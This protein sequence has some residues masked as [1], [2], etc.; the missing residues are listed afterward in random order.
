MIGSFLNKEEQT[1][2]FLKYIDF[3]LKGVSENRSKL[4]GFLS[5][6]NTASHRCRSFRRIQ[7][8]PPLSSQCVD[9]VSFLVR[10]PVRKHFMFLQSK[11]ETSHL[12][13]SQLFRVFFGRP[14]VGIIQ[15]RLWVE[16]L[17][18]LSAC[19]TSS[20][21]CLL[22]DFIIYLSLENGKAFPPSIFLEK[23]SA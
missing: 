5:R 15:I 6:R 18:F 10:E 19:Q 16:G 7:G 1:A 2:F 3:P 22:T 8:A 23:K 17:S 4:T 21:L 20:P 11:R 13:V 12:E 9:W 14:Y